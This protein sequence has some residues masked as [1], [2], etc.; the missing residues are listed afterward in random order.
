LLREI[1]EVETPRVFA[2]QMRTSTQRA[3]FFEQVSSEQGSSSS[4]YARDKAEAAGSAAL[5]CW[6]ENKMRGG[7]A[8][9]SD[10]HVHRDGGK[11][12]EA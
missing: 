1:R 10:E 12:A 7:A 5:I 8:F 2:R 9:Q 6:R 3:K 11:A 4:E